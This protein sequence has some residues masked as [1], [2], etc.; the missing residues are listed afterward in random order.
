MYKKLTLFFIP[1]LLITACSSDDN[2][3]KKISGQ[4]QL[5]AKVIETHVNKPIYFDVKNQEGKYITEETTIINLTNNE[6]VSQIGRFKPLRVGE[7][8]FKAKANAG[9][10]SYN[11]SNSITI[12]VTEPTEKTFSIKGITYKVDK[13]TLNIKK[14]QYKDD[15]GKDIIRDVVVFDKDYGHHNEYELIIEGNSP[16]H[17][18]V[19]ITFLVPN[20]FIKSHNGEIIE[21]GKRVYPH[22]TP[23]TLITNISTYTE[24]DRWMFRIINSYPNT[25]LEFYSIPSPKEDSNNQVLKNSYLALTFEDII[26]DYIGDMTF[27]DSIYKK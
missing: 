12:K 14:R 5:E 1:C 25:D 22:E 16:T 18:Y 8:T 26:I 27:K 6:S 10:A 13:A 19:S 3:S 2:S 7:Y 11:D 4:L 21:Y 24:K 17:A 20:T 23:T 9:G 15:L